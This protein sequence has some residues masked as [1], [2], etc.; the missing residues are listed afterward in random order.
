ME[1]LSDPSVLQVR[2]ADACV[3][4][5]FVEGNA[6]AALG[7]VYGGAPGCAWYPITPSSSLAEAFQKYC[8]KYRVDE[9]GT[10]RFAVIQAEL[11]IASIGMDVCSGWNVARAVTPTPGQRSLLMYEF[12]GRVFSA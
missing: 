5:I 3:D 1:H 6:D 9:Q 12:I 10:A 4:M 11:E 7:R 2:K 8:Q